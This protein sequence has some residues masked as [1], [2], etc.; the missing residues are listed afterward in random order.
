MLASLNHP[1][2][3]AIYGLEESD[4]VRALVMQLVEGETLRTPQPFETTLNYAGRSCALRDDHPR[5]G[6]E[7]FY[8]SSE[9]IMSSSYTANGEAFVASKP[10]LRAAKKD[11]GDIYDLA[12][13]GKRFALLQPQTS[14]QKGSTQVTFPAELLRRTAPPRASSQMNPDSVRR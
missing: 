1:N 4:G 7:S 3:A 13:D 10:R 5:E 9:G 11:L 6:Q 2:I 14:D 8:R 12:P